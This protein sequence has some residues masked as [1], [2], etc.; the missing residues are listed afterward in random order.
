MELSKVNLYLVIPQASL[1]AST[2]VSVEPVPR[3]KGCDD[4]IRPED[5]CEVE[6]WGMVDLSHPHPSLQWILRD[7]QRQHQGQTPISQ[8]QDEAPSSAEADSLVMAL[9]PGDPTSISSRSSRSVRR[10][11]VPALRPC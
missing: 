1:P 9:S 2:S 4:S 10:D 7:L 6:E 3:V 8:D 11:P 5:V